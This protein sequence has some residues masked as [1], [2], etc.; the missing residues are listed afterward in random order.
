M[1][2]DEILTHQPCPDCG[3]SDALCVYPDHTYCFSCETY[4]TTSSSS[5]PKKHIAKGLIPLGDIEVTPLKARCLTAEVCKK[6]NYG[7][8]YINNKV[9][10]VAT[11]C[12]AEGTPIFQKTRDA[13]KNFSILGNFQEVFYGQQ[14]FHGGRRLVITEGEI[15]CLSYSQITANKYAVVSLPSGAQSARKV[16]KHN[17]DWLNSFEEVIL[18]FDM[19]E[20]GQKAVASVEGLLP[21][22]KLKIARLPL[23]DANECLKAGR[24]DEVVR[25]MWDA[26]EY[27]PDG[28]VNAKDLKEELFSNE[29]IIKSYEFPW[30]DDLNKKTRGIRK[31]ELTLFTAGSGIG[32][33]TVAREVAYKLKMQD[34]R[35]I[36]MLML[37][38]KTTKTVRDILSIHLRKPLHLE[39][40]NKDTREEAKS[41]Y[42]DVFGDGGFVLYDHFGSLESSN[43]LNRI[44]YLAVAEECDFIILDHIS[45]A[46][47][48]LTFKDTSEVKAQ[49]ILMTQLRSLVAETGVGL[50][51]ISHLR[52]TDNKMKSFEEGGH[53]S[54]DSL[55][56]SGA[57]KQ[58]SDTIIAF[59]RNQQAKNETKRN[60]L[61]VRVLKCRF[62]GDTGE[63]SDTLVF[64]HATNRLELSDVEDFYEDEEPKGDF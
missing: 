36:G 57:L 48:G 44:R 35:K 16:F 34:H 28:I 10:Q 42:D 46:L 14:L 39:W 5:S 56:G 7:V 32:K 22:H 37:E 62:T 30:C 41:C 24:A 9:I 58:L 60:I 2:G 50:I 23:K 18:M 31:G 47:S 54:M 6:F 51:V 29:A 8:T 4:R 25:A 40:D 15:D 61:G 33:S 26:E 64:N 59:E 49:D 17:L 11:Y 20:A 52:K 55:R 19:D 12:D 13:N 63:V 3:S 43:L 45:I 27:R 21:P 38:E 53:I 1:N